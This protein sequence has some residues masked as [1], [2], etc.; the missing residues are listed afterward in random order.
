MSCQMDS[1]VGTERM[2]LPPTCPPCNRSETVTAWTQ[3]FLHTSHG[4]QGKGMASF[5]LCTVCDG[6]L[7]SSWKILEVQTGHGDLASEAVGSL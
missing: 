5:T 3:V 6:F 2:E 7:S 1:E 4:L